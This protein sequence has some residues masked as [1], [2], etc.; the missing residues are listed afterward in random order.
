[1]DANSLAEVAVSAL[2]DIKARDITVI[3]VSELTSLFERMIIASAVSMR[4][5]AF[6]ARSKSAAL[7]MP[8]LVGMRAVA[9][10]QSIPISAADFMYAS[11]PRKSVVE[12]CDSFS[13]GLRAPISGAAYPTAARAGSFAFGTAPLACNASIS[14]PLNPSCLRTSS[15]CSPSAGARLAGTLVMPCI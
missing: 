13:A 8:R 3:D 2:E 9:T 10:R 5:T 7:N 4:G 15:L 6:A 11:S 14:L 1:M 12:T